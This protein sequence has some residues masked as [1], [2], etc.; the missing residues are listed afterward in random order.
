MTAMFNTEKKYY[1]IS[2]FTESLASFKPQIPVFVPDELGPWALRYI[3]VTQEQLTERYSSVGKSNIRSSSS[4]LAPAWRSHN[5]LIVNQGHLGNIVW[6][7]KVVNKVNGSVDMIEVWRSREILNQL[8]N[9]EV[10]VPI[11]QATIANP[12]VRPARTEL[13]RGGTG[14]STG[15]GLT[16]DDPDT[17]L[18][19]ELEHQWQLARG[20][21]AMGYEIR[22]LITDI[23][24]IQAIQ[25]YHDLVNLNSP[26]VTVNTGWN[27]NLNP[28]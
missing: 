21:S 15:S 7:L 10:D 24:P 9:G 1:N 12:E 4:H 20:L 28:V 2:G 19:Y 18:V 6:R 5:A 17:P 23:S 25:V 27:K 11:E 13:E 16:I 3:F 14:L 26:D 22:Y 8:F